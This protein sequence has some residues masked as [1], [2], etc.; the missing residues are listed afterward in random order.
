MTEEQARTLYRQG[1]DA[2]VAILQD[3]FLR[4]QALEEQ[5]AKNSNNS[6]KYLIPLNS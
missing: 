6:S 2:V 4:V 5:V 3:V 1:E